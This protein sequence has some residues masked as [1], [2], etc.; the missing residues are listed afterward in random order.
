MED[1]GH[2]KKDQST[3]IQDELFSFAIK[4][5]N[6]RKL[7]YIKN[8]PFGTVFVLDCVDHSHRCI[9]ILISS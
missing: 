2:H 5:L 8:R 4:Q 1:K 9:L 3:N 6:C 7:H